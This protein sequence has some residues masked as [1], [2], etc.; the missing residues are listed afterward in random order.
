LDVDA[1]PC[2][3]PLP[4]L[5]FL[6][7]FTNLQE[8]V[9]SFEYCI[10]FRDFIEIQYVTFSHLHILNFSYECLYDEYFIKFLE[11]NGKNLKELY[12]NDSMNL[13]T[14]KFCPKLKLCS[15]FRSNEMG[16]L[17][18]IF[19]SCQELENVKVS[20]GNMYLDENELL[21]VVGKYSPKKF[22]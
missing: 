5:L 18:K 17:K 9:L 8:L 3:L 13:A 6:V 20:C 4:L 1:G 7:K 11:N 2:S 19:N 16:T 14:V 22:L 15:M 10:N 21:K 12:S